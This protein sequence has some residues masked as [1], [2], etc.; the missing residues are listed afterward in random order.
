MTNGPERPRHHVEANNSVRG[1]FALLA[2]LLRRNPGRASYGVRGPYGRFHVQH[3]TTQIELPVIGTWPLQD[4]TPNGVA[5]TLDRLVEDVQGSTSHC[6]ML[7]AYAMEALCAEI[8]SEQMRDDVTMDSQGG[9]RV[10]VCFDEG[11]HEPFVWIAT[12]DPDDVQWERLRSDNDLIEAPH[13]VPCHFF[14]HQRPDGTIATIMV[15]SCS[16]SEGIEFPSLRIDPETFAKVAKRVDETFD[17]VTILRM[18]REATMQM[19]GNHQPS[20]PKKAQIA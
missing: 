7:E 1:T 3:G 20:H 5:D 16:D 19:I 12:G 2:S 8:A 18:L 6:E 11:S 15:E 4:L 9:F 17:A 10:E 14:D 13:V